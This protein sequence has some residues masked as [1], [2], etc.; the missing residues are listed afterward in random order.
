MLKEEVHSLLVDNLDDRS[1]AKIAILDTGIDL[2]HIDMQAQEERIKSVRSWVGGGNGKEDR[3]GGD[4]YGHGTHAAG[5]LLDIAPQADI[6]IAR[7]AEGG[8]LKPTDQ[9]ADLIADVS[10]LWDCYS[11]E[12]TAF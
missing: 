5:L 7:I 1:R 10:H 4:W 12:L 11:L 3:K 2:S 6:Y 9:V 8:E